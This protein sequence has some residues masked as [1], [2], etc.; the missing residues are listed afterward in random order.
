MIITDFKWIK[1][2]LKK[3]LHNNALF[4]IVLVIAI[5]NI[6]QLFYVDDMTSIGV[7]VIAGVFVSLFS[8]NKIIIIMIST[9]IAIIFSGF[10]IE[11][12]KKKK[13]GVSIKKKKKKNNS[14]A[15][16]DESQTTNAA[17]ASDQQAVQQGSTIDAVKSSLNAAKDILELA[18]AK[19]AAI[20]VST[21]QA[22]T[23]NDS[24]EEDGG[25]SFG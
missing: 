18:E 4:Y 1:P 8:Q 21:T 3:I 12:F 6:I 25:F 9:I 17:V 14:S 15:A 7:F 2:L 11:G 24:T 22:T 5:V 19:V 10:V 13:K 16:S 20:G 23:T